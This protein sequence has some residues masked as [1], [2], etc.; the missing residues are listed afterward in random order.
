MG[1]LP[2]ANGTTFRVWAPHATAVSVV[3]TFNDWDAACHPLARDDHGR[4]ETWSTDVVSAHPGAEYRF[5]LQTP[6]GARWVEARERSGEPVP[7]ASAGVA[8]TSQ[9][10]PFTSSMPKSPARCFI[11]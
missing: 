2:H 4:A 9:A 5:V 7:V 3:G 1:A 10:I 6:A 8:R 11:R